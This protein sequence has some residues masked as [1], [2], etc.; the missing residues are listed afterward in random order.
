MKAIFPTKNGLVDVFNQYAKSFNLTR[1]VEKFSND[2]RY[3]LKQYELGWVVFSC[4]IISTKWKSTHLEWL[5]GAEVFPN[6]VDTEHQLPTIFA[7]HIRISVAHILNTIVL[8]TTAKGK[9]ENEKGLVI[10]LCQKLLNGI[11]VALKS[12]K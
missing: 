7:S 4:K 2:V 8:F 6:I 3:S 1:G 11:A 9:L 5:N 10:A 12:K